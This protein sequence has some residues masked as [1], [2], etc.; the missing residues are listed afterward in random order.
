MTASS[1]PGVSETLNTSIRRVLS[2]HANVHRA[3][4]FG[5]RAKGTFRDNSDIDIAVDGEVTP[6]EAAVIKGD[7]EELPCPL[8]FDVVSYRSITNEDLREHIDRVGL[9]VFEA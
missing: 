2:L 7:L 6:L 5:S 4:I 1:I 8:S 9:V 3:R